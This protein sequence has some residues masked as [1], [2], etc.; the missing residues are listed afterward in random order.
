MEEARPE[1]IPKPS[2]RTKAAA[3][4]SPAE[5]ARLGA[6]AIRERDA[7]ARRTMRLLR[8]ALLS[9]VEI[10]PVE[11]ITVEDIVET[12]GIGRST[13]Y[14]HFETKEALIE[15]IATTEIEQL[16]DLVFP[17]LSAT[18]SRVTCLALAGY[19]SDRRKLWSVLL[20]GGASA[21]MR[22]TFVRL[23]SARAPTSIAGFEPNLPIELGVVSG[24]G[25]TIEIL[26]WWLRQADP[27]SVQQLAEY[28]DRLSVRPALDGA[29]QG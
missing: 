5:F 20:T 7:R 26:A 23:A 27:V 15:E 19:V 11:R 6:P 29:R 9:L 4:L 24:V 25:A 17:L 8:D 18:D 13:F 2:K 1:Q 21:I 22:D 12:A 16:V 28:L 10:G 14:R 3:K